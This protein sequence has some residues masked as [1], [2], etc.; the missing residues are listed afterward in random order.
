[1]KIGNNRIAWVFLAVA[2]LV[3]AVQMASYFPRLPEKLATHF[4]AAG[5]ANGWMSKR[6]FFAFQF[7][8]LAIMGL[9]FCLLPQWLNRVPNA[10]INLPHKAYWLAPE[11]RAGGVVSESADLRAAGDHRR[12]H[13]ARQPAR[14][15]ATWW[16][17]VVAARRLRGVAGDLDC[18]FVPA[19]PATAGCLTGT[20]RQ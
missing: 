7:A 11:R 18:P 5:N 17:G 1:M 6:G 3:S 19:L 9:A 20:M 8:M 15:A 2:L 16:R 14:D 12:T 4:D 10:L 13:A